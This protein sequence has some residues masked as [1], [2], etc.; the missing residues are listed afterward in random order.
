MK[1]MHERGY[2]TGHICA[3]AERRLC[4]AF[5][6]T[7]YLSLH[8]ATY[9]KITEVISVSIQFLSYKVQEYAS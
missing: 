5:K 2:K 7:A 9:T 3:D 1:H 4:V 6:T 8:A